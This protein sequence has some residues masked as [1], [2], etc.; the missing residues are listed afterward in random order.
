[1]SSYMHIVYI[2]TYIGEIYVICIYRFPI[3]KP[4][5][6]IETDIVSPGICLVRKKY[7]ACIF[8]YIIPVFHHY[9]LQFLY[10]RGKNSEYEEIRDKK[11]KNPIFL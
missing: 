7:I 8:F 6:R 1:M 10:L 2:S 5:I 11:Y 9:S 3:R 4:S